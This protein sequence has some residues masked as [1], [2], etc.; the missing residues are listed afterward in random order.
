MAYLKNVTDAKTDTGIGD[1]WFKIS[2]QGFDAATAKW[3]VDDLVASGGIQDI[4]IPACI[5]DGQYLLRA[6][7]I[8]L[9]GA[10]SS[11]GA[12][13]YMECAQINVTGGKGAVVPATVSIPGAY[14]ATDPGVL[15]GIYYPAITSYTIPGPK[16]FQC[17][18]GAAARSEETSTSVNSR[19]RRG[20]R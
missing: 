14:S 12:Q 17:A 20:V 4:P 15:I 5:A 10:G 16:V 1:G 19:I 11:G 8:A 6:E 7:L 13:F 18:A 2:E 3:A 9:H